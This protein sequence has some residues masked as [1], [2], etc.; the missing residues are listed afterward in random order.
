MARY[1]TDAFGGEMAIL[2]SF[3]IVKIG[4]ERRFFAREIANRVKQSLNG[5]SPL[6]V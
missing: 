4:F 6:A 3:L 1:L 5:G 2:V